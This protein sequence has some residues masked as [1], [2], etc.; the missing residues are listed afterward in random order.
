MGLDIALPVLL[1]NEIGQQEALGPY[2]YY[3]AYADNLFAR[4]HM[5]Q[6]VIENLPTLLFLIVRIG[7]SVQ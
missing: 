4:S 6:M 3:Y 7:V 2:P 1:R 5:N